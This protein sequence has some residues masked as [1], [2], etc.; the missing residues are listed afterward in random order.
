M[1]NKSESPEAG[2]EQ[3]LEA[4]REEIAQLAEQERLLKLSAYNLDATFDAHDL[5]EADRVIW[6]KVK[7]EMVDRK[8][9]DTYRDNVIDP[10][11][12][13]PR[14]DMPT[15]RFVFFNF[16]TNKVTFLLYKAEYEELK[17][18]KSEK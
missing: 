5:A 8:D 13:M 6:D 18:K 16:I 7:A 9:F 4:F 1:A 11:T 10:E 3:E 2:N 15:S 17:K 14:T 12:R